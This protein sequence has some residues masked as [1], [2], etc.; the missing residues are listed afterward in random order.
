MK[1]PKT[2]SKKQVISSIWFLSPIYVVIILIVTGVLLWYTVFFNNIVT[3]L[4]NDTRKRNV[5]YINN[6]N[7]E[8]SDAVVMAEHICMRLYFDDMVRYYLDKNAIYEYDDQLKEIQDRI[9]TEMIRGSRI[10][11][12][13]VYYQK[14]NDIITRDA[15]I[16]FDD[17]QNVKWLEYGDPSIGSRTITPVWTVSD[18]KDGK[19]IKTNVISIIRYFPVY[20]IDNIGAVVVNVEISKEEEAI[21]Y[22]DKTEQ[23]TSFLLNQVGIVQA[24]GSGGYVNGSIYNILG[25]KFD[26]ARI[27]REQT[28]FNNE[29]VMIYASNE[30]YFDWSILQIYPVKNIKSRYN[31]L[32]KYFYV[33]LL[34]CIMGII[35]LLAF[36]KKMRNANLVNGKP[37]HNI[38]DIIDKENKATLHGLFDTALNIAGKLD[39]EKTKEFAKLGFPMSSYCIVLIKLKREKKNDNEKEQECRHGK[40]VDIINKGISNYSFGYCIYKNPDEFI[41]AIHIPA[42][43]T[44]NDTHIF[45]KNIAEYLINL[46]KDFYACS[47]G[48]SVGSHVDKFEELEVSL[49]TARTMDKY[50]WF[51]PSDSI[52]FYEENLKNNRVQY[53]YNTHLEEKLIDSIR[54]GN[55]KEAIANFHSFVD[56]L[57][58]GN[59]FSP[60]NVYQ[61]MIQ[62]TCSIFRTAQSIN[63]G[64]KLLQNEIG[65]FLDDPIVKFIRI[66]SFNS[67][68]M[69]LYGVIKGICDYR[70]ETRGSSA[71]EAIILDVKEYISNN[72]NKGLTLSLVAEEFN[73][74]ESYLS[75]VFKQKTGENFL[76]YLNK[77]RINMAKKIMMQ[78]RSISISDVSSMVGF[79]NVQTFIRVFKRM[80][81][82]ITPGAYKELH[83]KDNL[84]I[85]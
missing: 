50:I 15:V 6:I 7:K 70:W 51:Q 55:E 60:K 71:F 26:I 78:K 73:I 13:Y 77:C 52:E 83:Y 57:K 8:F 59:H 76:E 9:N 79:E 29:S 41:A 32:W 85:T 31:V 25:R 42:C 39:A 53:F 18:Y 23:T 10:N 72:Y 47:I 1:L 45:M 40:A 24:S 63:D 37:V 17:F 56:D 34:L 3:L 46:L 49:E 21:A 4:E 75:R 74:S 48:V 22:L 14:Q 65:D 80:E 68:Q 62:I 54:I 81:G 38:I 20:T 30:T 2:M 82:G 36:S 66:E 27:N 11:S 58:S 64:Q 61:G 5:T 44:T 43:D 16:P 67:V 35:V 69:W 19:N 33:N 28:R 84:D 12:I